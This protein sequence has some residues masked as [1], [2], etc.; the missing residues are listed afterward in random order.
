MPTIEQIWHQV[1]PPG[2]KFIHGE[3][4]IYDQVSWV[5][6]LRPTPP[7]FDRL[8]GSELALIDMNN[9]VK[10]GANLLS[11]VSSIVEQGAS[12]FGVLGEITDDVIKYLKT[13]ETPLF[14]FP[15][16]INLT[17]L[18][19]HISNSIREEK[20]PLYQKE[21]DLT[22]TLI[23][24]ALAGHGTNA[25]LDKLQKLTGSTII[26]VNHNFKPRVF[27]TETTIPGVQTALSKRFS[28]PPSSITGVKLSESFSCFISP[29][30]GKLGTEGYL[31]VGTEPGELKEFDRVAAKVGSLALAMELSRR[32]GVEDTETK[33]QTEMIE[34]LFSGDL[35]PNAIIE[36]ASKLGLDRSLNYVVLAL[37]TNGEPKTGSFTRRIGTLLGEEALCYHRGDTLVVLYQVK[38]DSTPDDLRKLNKEIARKIEGQIGTKVTM[39]MGRLYSGPEGL[40]NSLQEAE[41]ALMMGRRLFSDGSASYFGDLGIYRLLLS[42][43]IEEL[44]SFYQESIGCLVEY[45]TEHHGELLHTLEEI[46]RYPTVAETAKALHVH[47]N[48]LLYRIQRIQEITKLNLDDGETRLTLHLALNA[49]D[50]I[51]AG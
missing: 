42:L 21:Q 46:L 25:I 51:R 7:G 39:G 22:A 31:L 13:T 23:D 5:V 9:A 47:R 35:S 14:S 26:L 27:N 33:F 37:N 3:T 50:V 2:T 28:S 6:T 10:L 17:I 40:R 36:R 1:M 48:T 20:D 4:G 16:G 11:L 15:S 24:L 32:Q 49:A 38:P 43:K 34:S 44:K 19:Q 45:D 12:S 29:V 41:Q 18:E 30:S 8:H